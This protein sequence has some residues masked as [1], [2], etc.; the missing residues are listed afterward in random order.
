MVMSWMIV[1][2][3][4]SSIY[5]QAVYRKALPLRM[6]RQCVDGRK[7]SGVSAARH[8]RGARSGIPVWLRRREEMH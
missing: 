8:E 3:S 7:V 5:H 2:F 4:K 6:G 1:N